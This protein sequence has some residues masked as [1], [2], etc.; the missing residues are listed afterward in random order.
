MWSQTLTQLCLSLCC[1]PLT[2]ATRDGQSGQMAKGTGTVSHCHLLPPQCR[3][4]VPLWLLHSHP[5]H[6]A[7]WKQLWLPGMLVAPPPSLWLVAMQGT[8][9]ARRKIK[10][11][12]PG[13]LLAVGSHSSADTGPAAGGA[14]GWLSCQPAVPIFQCLGRAGY[15]LAAWHGCKF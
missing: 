5:W 13:R 15:F 10:F 1:L 8:S 11:L 14:T 12:I 9:F 4:A 7:G 6:T 2:R 3:G